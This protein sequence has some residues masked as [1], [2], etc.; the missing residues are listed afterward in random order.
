MA[1]DEMA[2]VVGGSSG[3]GAA[4]AAR[5]RAHGA[6]VLVWDIKEPCDVRCDVSDPHAIEASASSTVDRIG[7][8]TVVTV[9]AGIGH[10]GL[11][12]DVDPDDWDR[13]MTVNVRGPWLVMRSMA[14]RMI[15]AGIAGS[16]VATSSVSAHLVDRNMG[17]YCASKAALNMTVK[18]AAAEWASSRI[19]VNA[20]G[21]G[22]TDTPMLGGAP[23]DRGWL[24]KVAGRTALGSI[25]SADDVADAIVALHQLPW[26]TGQVL[27]AD[28]GLGL[29]SPIDA[30]AEII[31]RGSAPR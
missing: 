29:H 1:Q 2:V 5:Q 26:V 31:G 23:V 13:V 9:C 30:Y 17:A 19:R 18:V 15:D 25:G 27:D 7:V 8:P 12:L 14:R 6:T 3:I 22:V 20:V 11:L 16:I 24:A 28:G 10:S 4:V 21:P